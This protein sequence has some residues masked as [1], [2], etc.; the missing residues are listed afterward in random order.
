MDA[1]TALCSRRSIR[2]Y[3]GKPVAQELVREL[4]NAAMSAPSAGNERPWHF[5]VL[6]DRLILDS[7]PRFHPYAAMLKHASVAILVCG[8]VSLERHKGYWVLDC[9]AAT[10]NI[11]VA[12]HAKGLGAVWCGVYPTEDRVAGFRSLLG[13]PEQIVPFSLVPLGF[14]AEI[15]HAGDRYEADR[16]HENRWTAAA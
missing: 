16:V 4:L 2:L 13:L 1:L 14:P 11:L 15:K 12:A 10:E 5:I 9:A 7:I 3:T 8:D 6:T